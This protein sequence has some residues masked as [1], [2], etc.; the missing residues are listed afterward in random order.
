MGWDAF[1]LPAENAAMQKRQSIR[2]P[3][4]TTNIDAMR[5]QL[6]AMG[7]SLDWS[8]EFATCDPE[9][10]P[11]S[12]GCSSTSSRKAWSPQEDQG[13]L[14]PGRQTVLANEQVIDGRGWR[15]GALVEQRELTQW[16]LKITAYSDDL[17][18]ALDRLDRLARQSAPHAAQLD[19]PLRRAAD[20]VRR[21]KAKRCRRDIETLE[22]FTTRPDTI[23]GMSFCAHFARPSA[24][25]G[26]GEER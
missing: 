4:P 24:G 13:Q 10:Y 2:R 19:R 20:A 25:Q 5:G 26:A 1:G 12:S 17:L 18:A 3:G 7:L 16:F 9:Y 22:V 11:S 8:R 6:K 14:G 15:S 23:F 21:W